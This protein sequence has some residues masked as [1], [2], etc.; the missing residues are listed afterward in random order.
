MDYIHK[1]KCKL[2]IHSC[3]EKV[4]HRRKYY[5]SHWGSL[6]LAIYH[7][8][9]LKCGT[10]VELTEDITKPS[11]EELISRRDLT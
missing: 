6:E 5:H 9:C 4:F 11:I 3:G 8:K 1:I 7:A 10:N 2:G